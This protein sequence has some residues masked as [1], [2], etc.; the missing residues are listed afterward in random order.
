[1]FGTWMVGGCVCEYA[2]RGCDFCYVLVTDGVRC[3]PCL[4]RGW[5]VGVCVSMLFVVVIFVVGF[6]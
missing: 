5:L 2:V 6:K 1:M 4:V 3:K